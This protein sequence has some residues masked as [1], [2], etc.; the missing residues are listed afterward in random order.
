M[1][2][3]INLTVK[4]IVKKA[5]C[6]TNCQYRCHFSLYEAMEIHCFLYFGSRVTHSASDS[7]PPR[8]SAKVKIFMLDRKSE[9]ICAAGAPEAARLVSNLKLTLVTGRREGVR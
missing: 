2:V 7:I 1:G 3:C 9:E 8:L 4:E 5:E 6:D